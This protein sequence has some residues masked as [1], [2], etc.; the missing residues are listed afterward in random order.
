[1]SEIRL[2]KLL[3]ECGVASRRK[4]E[5]LI[6]RGKV[7]VN[8]HVAGLGDKAD[9]HKDIVT[10]GGRR[11]ALP[12]RKRYIMLYKPRGYVTTLND[13]MGRKCVAELVADAGDRLFPVGRLDRDSEGLLLLTN[14]GDFANAII[15]PV[16]HVPKVYR[17]TIRP[18]ISDE[19]LRQFASGIL[20]EGESRPTAP[21]DIVVLS[22]ERLQ[23]GTGSRERE[24]SLPEQTGDERVIVEVT[25]YEGRNR[26]IRRMFEQMGI[27]VARL[28]RV[29]LGQVKLGML[30]PGK[31][32]ELE[33]REV[34]ALMQ[35]AAKKR[36]AGP[37]GAE[38]AGKA[39]K[40]EKTEK[41]G[42]RN[43][44]GAADDRHSSRR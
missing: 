34:Q 9:P 15:H 12:A 35:A 30:S 37:A 3:S 7:K 32:R 13:E 4:A 16:S 38:K 24:D 31:W 21:A 23:E 36:E 43:K 44:G 26:Q 18:G 41:D 42:K 33:P 39:R 2:Q 17:V 1:M 25:L 6:V 40:S 28:R 29:A 10:V 5:E 8:G 20:L 19:Q 27:E 14:D 22:R 11:I